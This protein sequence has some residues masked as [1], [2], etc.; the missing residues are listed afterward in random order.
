[1]TFLHGADCFPAKVRKEK[2]Q[3]QRPLLFSHQ[4]RILAS[5]N[6]SFTTSYRSPSN[7]SNLQVHFAIQL[8]EGRDR[9]IVRFVDRAFPASSLVVVQ[10]PVMSD[11]ATGQTVITA[12]QVSCASPFPACLETVY[13]LQFEL[14]FESK[15]IFFFWVY[16]QFYPL[17]YCYQTQVMQSE[18]KPETWSQEQRKGCIVGMQEGGRAPNPKVLKVS[19][20]AKQE[21]K[22]REGMVSCRRL[23]SVETLFFATVHI[24]QV[25]L[26]TFHQNFQPVPINFR[27]NKEPKAKGSIVSFQP[28]KQSIQDRERFGEVWGPLLYLCSLTYGILKCLQN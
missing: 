11:S 24:S 27:H 23:L 7:C 17:C 9:V 3:T 21:G 26:L 8:M 10:P 28:V 19:N 14:Q 6:E 13:S 25:L 4:S 20:K 18:A 15:I 12:Q 22:V 16:W 5:K 2:K 1:M